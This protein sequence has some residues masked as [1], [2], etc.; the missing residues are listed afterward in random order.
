MASYTNLNPGS[1]RFQARAASDDGPWST[2]TT[3]FRQGAFF[4][5]TAW[6]MTLSAILVIGSIAGAHRTRVKVVRAS[7]ERFK[8]LFDRNPAGEYRANASGR[9]LACHEACPRM[10]GF[11]SRAELMAH[12]L[13]ER[14]GSDM[15]WQTMVARLRDQ[16]SLASFETA[17]RRVDGTQVWV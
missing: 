5:Q 11:A 13:S 1:Y 10:L 17:L 8:P 3:M 6:F 7:A 16:G 12:G 15:G 14:S 4:Y 9:I 2:G